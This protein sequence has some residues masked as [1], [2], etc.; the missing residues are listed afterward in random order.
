MSSKYWY[1]D[2]SVVEYVL[3]KRQ[4]HNASAVLFITTIASGVYAFKLK[5]HP[6]TSFVTKPYSK[7]LSIEDRATNVKSAL[8]MTENGNILR[9]F[10]IGY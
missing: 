2:S 8:Q 9:C 7:N 1:T 5:T 4:W 3:S 10:G 6:T